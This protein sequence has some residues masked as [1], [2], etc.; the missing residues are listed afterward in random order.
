MPDEPEASSGSGTDSLDG[1]TGVFWFDGGPQKRGTLHLAKN[2]LKV[3]TEGIARQPQS[4]SF[5]IGDGAASWALTHSGRPEDAVAD[6]TA[7]PLLATLDDGRKITV[8]DARLAAEPPIGTQD[9]LGTKILLGAHA[10]TRATTFAAARVALPKAVVGRGIFRGSAP[11]EVALGD[12]TGELRAGVDDSG[13]LQLTLDGGF[14]EMEWERRFWNRCLTLL[15]LWTNAALREDR[16][17]LALSADGTWADLIRIGSNEPEP[18]N[19]R[20]S[21][22]PPHTLTIDTMAT[23]LALFDEL[24]PVPDVASRHMVYT[25]TLEL[26]VLANA[27]CLEGLH[28]GTPSGRRPFPA[29]KK[30]R[31]IAKAAA[32]AAADVAVQLGVLKH[33]HAAAA[34]AR[35]TETFSFFTEPTFAE[36]LEELLPPVEYVAPGLIGQDR[37][38]WISSVKNARNLEAHRLA[39]T[40]PQRKANHEQH[41][42]HYYQL[43]VSTEWVLRISLLLHLGVDPETLH[44]RLLD[45]R[46]F[47]FAL[48]NMDISRFAWPGS[49]LKEFQASRTRG[50]DPDEA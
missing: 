40:P 34:V 32:L 7:V 21:L 3:I 43:A 39:K 4:Y 20:E 42:D 9:I 49:R 22:L 23:A 15:R 31:P 16:I 1:A 18:F 27:S 50:T 28:R 45:H 11:L 10:P 13:W 6:N 8:R 5:S 29:I 25:V 30:P 12:V 48:A 47:L 2:G 35:L 26:A 36:R 19:H 33:E 24:A 41:I 37:G 14:T 38:F 44:A 46:N 17:Q